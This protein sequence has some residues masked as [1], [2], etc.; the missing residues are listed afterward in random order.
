MNLSTSS[1]DMNESYSA[2]QIR[3]QY[4]KILAAILIGMTLS[5][6]LVRIFTYAND[7]SSSTILGRV[8]EAK[9]ALPKIVKE[10]DDLVM[11]FGS[12][13]VDA[14]FSARQ[15]DRELA[16]QGVRVKSFNFGFGGLNPLF[17]D[18]WSRRIKDEFEA[19]NRRLK[20]A[21]IEFNPFQTTVTRRH[22]AMSAEDSFIGLL[23]SP[24]EL[25]DI[26]LQ[27]PARGV[28]MYNIRY[29]RDGISAEMI[30]SVFSREFQPSRIR[31]EL[32]EDESIAE[33]RNEL[34]GQLGEA[35]SVD[36]PDFDDS[37]WYYPWQGAGTIPEER[38]PETLELFEKYFATLR[39][40][41]QLDDDRL[42]RIQS[43]DIIELNFDETL[44]ESF[45]TLVKNFQAFSDH[46]EVIL[47]PKNTAWINN[48]PEAMQ[49][50][51][52]VLDRI[53]AETGV[54]IKDFQVIDAVTPDMFSDTTH[55]AR[56]SGDIAF[57][58]FLVEEY[59]QQL[60]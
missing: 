51:Q 17:Q 16:E 36:Y 24:K 41:Y 50:M 20:L 4:A 13:M 30:T 32:V 39:T 55:L 37:D 40:D 10:P 7:A 8:L 46:V 35:F 11:M 12:S 44:V 14:G 31:T 47:L 60:K 27:D 21:I 15:F 38:S 29:I 43:A 52:V 57:T 45:I 18:Y 33:Q 58:H 19:E 22:G 1:S 53:V 34:G 23:A 9:A 28:R 59:A 3:K 26:S 42:S 54:T 48:P 56:Y 49:R 5:M 6:V 25:W 2:T